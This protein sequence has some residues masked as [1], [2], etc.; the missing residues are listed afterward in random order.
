MNLTEVKLGVSVNFLL[1]SLKLMH[2][3]LPKLTWYFYLLAH[4]LLA[5]YLQG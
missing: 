5:N 4:Y 1:F 3:F 2:S